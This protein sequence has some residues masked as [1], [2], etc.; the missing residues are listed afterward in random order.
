MVLV[1]GLTREQLLAIVGDARM[2]T[3]APLDLEGHGSSGVAVLS[4]ALHQR[5]LGLELAH[6]ACIDARGEED[7]V[8]GRPL[9]VPTPPRAPTA[10]TFVA[11]RDDASVAWTTE[12][13]AAFRSAG[14]AVTSLG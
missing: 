2:A 7:P 8:S 9:V 1:D 14:W 12:T 3:D 13:A 10:I 5:R 11:G 4:L 6:V